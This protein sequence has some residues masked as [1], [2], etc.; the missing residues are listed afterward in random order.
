MLHLI[1]DGAF[2]TG[3]QVRVDQG[4]SKK[5][6]LGRTRASGASS[7][8]LLASDL[9]TVLRHPVPL[10]RPLHQGFSPNSPIGWM[11]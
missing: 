9:L 3:K 5:N 10:N 7:D 1:G 2:G 8:R 11:W 4:L 6:A